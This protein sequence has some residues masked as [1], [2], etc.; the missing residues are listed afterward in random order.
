MP[1][2]AGCANLFSRAAQTGCHNTLG[3]SHSQFR[4]LEHE[5]AFPF[6][7]RTV[8]G[9]TVRFKNTEI[10]AYMDYCENAQET[11]Q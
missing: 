6:K 5:G 7:R 4:A 2:K 9:R 3:V 10:I 11:R 1:R 8:G